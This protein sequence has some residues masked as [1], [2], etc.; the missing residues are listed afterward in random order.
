M[1][2]EIF[3]K[4]YSREALCH[5]V[6]YEARKALYPPPIKRNIRAFAS[7]IPI[8]VGIKI[9]VTALKFAAKE[10]IRNLVTTAFERACSDVY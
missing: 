8:E 1:E 7:I 6:L 5:E 10:K 3:D 9:I 4:C 2:V